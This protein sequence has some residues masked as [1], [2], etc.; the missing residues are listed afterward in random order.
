MSITKESI[1]DK[2]ENNHLPLPALAEVAIR[3]WE[4]IGNVDV[5][6]TEVSQITE[7]ETALSARIIQVAN[8]TLYRGLS[9]PDNTQLTHWHRWIKTSVSVIDRP[10][11]YESLDKIDMTGGVIEIDEIREA[12]F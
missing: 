12:I 7:T 8:S 9:S 3:V 6:I 4:T 2:L 11:V 1:L 5:C 10:G